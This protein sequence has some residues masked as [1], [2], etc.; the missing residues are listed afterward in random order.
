[1][2]SSSL[3]S[4]IKSQ[5]T[6]FGKYLQKQ[7][8]ENPTK[9]VRWTVGGVVS[10]KVYSELKPYDVEL[11]SSNKY[12]LSGASAIVSWFAPY[13]ISCLFLYDTIRQV[14]DYTLQVYHNTVRDS[15]TGEIISQTTSTT[16]IHSGS[17]PV[18]ASQQETTSK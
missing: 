17:R 11:G 9:F 6:I 2:S 14:Q 12:W 16:Q 7:T 13:T 5:A 1:M 10:Y 8:P 4:K 18:D 3:F 15:A